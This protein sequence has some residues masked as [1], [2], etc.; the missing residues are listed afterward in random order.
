MNNNMK[1]MDPA[2][3]TGG[4][5]GGSTNAAPTSVG[6][7][8]SN[9]G[10][11]TPSTVETVSS[12]ED[13]DIFS[14]ATEDNI[15]LSRLPEKGLPAPTISPAAPK[16]AGGSVT[17]D[18]AFSGAAGISPTVS[19]HPTTG[20]TAPAGVG[21][22]APGTVPSAPTQLTA[23]DIALATAQGV[24]QALTPAKPAP[25]Q[26]TSDQVDEMLGVVK[27]KAEDMVAYGL[28][29]EAAPAM[30]KLAN[31]IA[32]NAIKTANVLL[33]HRLNQ[34]DARLA[35]HVQYVQEQ[36]IRE[37]ENKF[38]AANPDLAGFEAV[39]RDQA[40]KLKATGYKGT[41]EE[42]SKKVADASR[43]FLKT[44]GVDPKTKTATAVQVQQATPPNGGSPKP[45]M[46]T[47]AAA[48]QAGTGNASSKVNGNKA[49]DDDVAAIFARG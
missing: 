32:A 46:S 11:A 22:A 27:L 30:N 35:P 17:D 13:L 7:E 16:I 33:E 15:P 10:S 49:S 36:Q 43:E 41:F 26:L 2:V 1:L 19:G 47:L 34:V 42:A 40:D 4:S 20:G 25:T 45:N 12:A 44:L 6:Q 28:P 5:E 31:Q 9:S 48:G 18:S 23:Q 21:G 39:V 38:S 37:I 3:T 24:K 14:P 8:S 29:P